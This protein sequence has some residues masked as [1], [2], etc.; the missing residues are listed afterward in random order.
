VSRA[1]DIGFPI[2]ETEDAFDDIVDVCEVAAVMS[3]IEDVDGLSG[4]YAFR[5]VEQGHVGSAPRTVYGK[6]P[7]SRRRHLKEMAIRMRHQFVGL[8]PQ[9]LTGIDA[10]VDG[11]RHCLFA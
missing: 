6:E 10:V 7:Q 1:I 8:R 11:K 2:E 5:E 4:Q 3:V 9:R